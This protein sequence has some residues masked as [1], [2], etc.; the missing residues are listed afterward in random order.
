MFTHILIKIFNLIVYDIL[1]ELT[2][3]PITYLKENSQA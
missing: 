3:K 2:L 1:M